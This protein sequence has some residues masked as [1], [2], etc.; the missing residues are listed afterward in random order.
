MADPNTRDERP[1]PGEPGHLVIDIG[2]KPSFAPDIASD[3]PAAAPPRQFGE[4]VGGKQRS[5]DAGVDYLVQRQKDDAEALDRLAREKYGVPSPA[6]QATPAGAPAS[7]PGSSARTDAGATPTAAT[8]AIGASS[9]SPA[10]ASLPPQGEAGADPTALARPLVDGLKSAAATVGRELVHAP[11]AV[12]AGMGD[13]VVELARAGDSL[14]SWLNANVVDL[15]LPVLK[16]GVDPLDALIANPAKAI[17]GLV[18]AITPTAGQSATAPLIKEVAQFLTGMALGGKLLKGAAAL[19]ASTA[20]KSLAT[21]AMADALMFDPKEENLAAFLKK[22]P[23]L[24]KVVPDFLATSPDDN[25]ALNRLRRAVEGLGL[26]VATEGLMAAF[27]AYR[28]ARAAQAGEK[29]TPAE[30]AKA[31]LAEQEAKYG[32]LGSVDL[33]KAVGDAGPDAPLVART[34]ADAAAA[35]DAPDPAALVAGAD[36]LA[37]RAEVLA[38]HKPAGGDLTGGRIAINWSRISTGDDVKVAMR[39]LADLFKDEIAKA[40]RGKIGT[41][42][43]QKLAADLGLTVDDLLA[44]REGQALNA[45]QTVA[46]RQLLSAASERTLETARLAA[47]PNAGP[48]ELFAYRRAVATEAAVLQEVLAARAEAGRALNAWK[49]PA[50]ASGDVERSRAIL[51][52]LEAS[53]GEASTRE[54]ARRHRILLESGAEP[55]GK[56]D[57][58]EAAAQAT[59][60]EMVREVWVNGLLGSPATHLVNA[61]SNTLVMAQQMIERG[62]A[63]KLSAAGIGGGGVAPGEAA[64]MMAGIV[65]AQ[66]DAWRMAWISMRTGETGHALGKVDLQ[67][68]GAISAESFRVQDNAVAKAVDFLGTV[69]RMPSRLLGTADEYFKTIG[70]RMEVNA[71]AVRQAT[72]EG[73]EGVALRERIAELVKNPPENIRLEAADAA[74]YMTFTQNAGQAAEAL[75]RLREKWPV[76]FF[77]FP[78][79]KTPVNIARYGFERTPIA[80]FMSGVKADLAA[81]GARQQL[82][83]AR[84]ATGTSIMLMAADYADRGLIT[85]S[86]PKDTGRRDALVRQG[87]QPFSMRVGDKWVAYD[88]T[89][90]YGMLMG[91][92]AEMAE[93]NRTMEI[94]GDKLDEFSELFAAG[95]AA[96]SS[97]V[98][99]KQY[100]KGLSDITWALNDPQRR[101]FGYVGGL[102][103]SVVPGAVNFARRLDDPVMREHMKIWDFV[104]GRLPGFAADLEPAL[105]LWGKPRQ[106]ESGYGPEADAIN[107]WRIQK[108]IASPV[109]AEMERLRMGVERIDKKSMVEGVAINFRDWPKVY[110]RYAQLA[111]N[112]LKHPAWKLGAKDYLDA[113]VEGRHP[114]SPIYTKLSDGPDGGK[115]DFIRATIRDYRKLAQAAILADPAFRDFK[116]AWRDQQ[117]IQDQAKGTFGGIAVPARPDVPRIAPAGTAAPTPSAPQ[118]P[119]AS[120]SPMRAP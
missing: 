7:A 98:I 69:E 45:E 14:A 2:R 64:A 105:D 108:V 66:K 40:R 78:F 109:D 39:D 62:I 43:T 35:K 50:A 112:E 107:P 99:N 24:E 70:Y 91:F 74:L 27:R 18:D 47:A 4:N 38:E 97:T 75:V 3:G 68:A 103:G 101:A 88:R 52:A 100:L 95:I 72:S 96:V 94:D 58:V 115:A 49:I 76:T 84:I 48:V 92:A 116:D 21:G 5:D 55:G 67:R 118:A 31:A 59:K 30:A 93:I 119:P 9:A 20:G 81:G 80:F 46:A 22:V 23:A 16:T 85:G 42:E 87:W 90:P 113:V 12:G 120:I 37:R 25:E 34:K 33:G 73:L 83:I 8:P 1:A 114:M 106:Q 56:R 57:F 102:A 71:Q 89:D 19:P 111:G 26:G 17:A 82:A 10:E 11:A 15:T 104:Q 53:G 6:G 77:V 32:K 86:G 110:T 44:R 54:I 60:W 63:E 28:A 29:P 51:E 65:Q 117:A 61:A 41:D 79:I 36:D 13:A